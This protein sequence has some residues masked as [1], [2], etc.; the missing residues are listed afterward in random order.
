MCHPERSETES[1][2]LL[3]FHSRI[4]RLNGK[5]FRCLSESLPY[6][7]RWFAKQTG[8]IVTFPCL[9]RLLK[10][11]I[12]ASPAGGLTFLSL[13]KKVSKELSLR[14]FP[15]KDSPTSCSDGTTLSPFEWSRWMSGD[16]ADRLSEGK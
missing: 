2:D 16:T 5:I 1:K 15:L 7:G 6:K 8:G 4:A 10:R 11:S 12:P 13:N 9:H 3:A 14:G